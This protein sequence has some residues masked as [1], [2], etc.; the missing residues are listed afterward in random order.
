MHFVIVICSENDQEGC[1]C[2]AC[3]PKADLLG[4]RA[5]SVPGSTN[6]NGL[7]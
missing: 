5:T 7:C 6:H 2:L 4:E 3:N 1:I